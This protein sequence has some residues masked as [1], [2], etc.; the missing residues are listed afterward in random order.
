[1]KAYIYISEPIH[2]FSDEA[3]DSLIED[4]I[5][6]NSDA[7]ITGFLCYQDGLFIQYFEGEQQAVDRLFLR[8]YQDKRHKLLNYHIR[9]PISSPKFPH[10]QMKVIK[11]ERLEANNI[12]PFLFNQ[13]KGLKDDNSSHFDW[14]SMVWRGVD[15]IAKK[16]V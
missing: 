14:Q 11:K 7:G 4:S 9:E 8:I 6:R 3:L 13:L 10:W 5:E 2:P 15:M 16:Y 12:K 1:M